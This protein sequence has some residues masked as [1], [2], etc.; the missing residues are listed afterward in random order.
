MLFM[1]GLRLVV[2]N[3]SRA[4]AGNGRAVPV[5]G[6][7]LSRLPRIQQRGS[8]GKSL[9]PN[10]PRGDQRIANRPR[11]AGLGGQASALA[12]ANHAAGLDGHERLTRRPADAC[13]AGAKRKSDEQTPGR[14]QLVQSSDEVN[15]HVGY[16]SRKAKRAPLDPPFGE[17]QGT[18]R[19]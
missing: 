5:S 7:S 1:I 3:G 11:T 19:A 14:V 2:E 9:R 13:F 12:D 15:D 18:A 8:H 10:R 4:K 17:E 16:R 6:E